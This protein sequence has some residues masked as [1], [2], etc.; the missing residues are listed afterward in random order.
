[1]KKNKKFMQ[2]GII[3][4]NCQRNRTFKIGV[5]GTIPKFFQDLCKKQSF[6][7]SSLYEI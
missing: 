1:M 4:R 5:K 6:D 2:K 3:I 7:K